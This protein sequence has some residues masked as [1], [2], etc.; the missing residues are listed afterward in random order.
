MKINQ[1]PVRALGSAVWSVGFPEGTLRVFA[2]AYGAF[3][4]EREDQ[5]YFVT[6]QRVAEEFETLRARFAPPD[7]AMT[8]QSLA[9]ATDNG[10]MK[11]IGARLRAFRLAERTPMEA[12]LL[13]K[14][15]QD[16]LD[17]KMA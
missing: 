9:S 2:A 10:R 16:I 12:M 7:Q 1:R 5:G 14:E 4:L 8:N 3:V 11:V 6:E 15:L 13:V 17:P